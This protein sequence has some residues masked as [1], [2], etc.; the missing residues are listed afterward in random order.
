MCDDH[1]LITLMNKDLGAFVSQLD[2]KGIARGYTE[3]MEISFVR[4]T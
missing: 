2:I 4:G 3:W 1:V